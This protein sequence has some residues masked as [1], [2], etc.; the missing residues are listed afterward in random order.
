ML[1]DF[2]FGAAASLAVF[3]FMMTIGFYMRHGVWVWER[4]S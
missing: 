2:T 4:L 3:V 1:N